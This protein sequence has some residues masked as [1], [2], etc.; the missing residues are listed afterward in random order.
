MVTRE[1]PVGGART[2]QTAQAPEHFNLI[3]LHWRGSG[4]VFFR[5]HGP[6]GWSPWHEAGAEAKDLPDRGSAEARRT[7]SW[8]IGNPFWT[9]TAD[10][11]QIRTRGRVERVR[12]HFVWSPEESELERRLQIAG[13]PPII[14]RQSWGADERIRRGSP[15][16][17]STL[18][19]TIV[20][21]TAGASP[22]SRAE[23]A[24]IV[25][26]IYTYHVRGNGWNDVGYNFLVDRFGQV[27]EGRYGGIERNV[28]GAHAVGFNTGS[29]GIA[30]L[31]SYG[32]AAPAPQAREAV[33]R[34][35]AWRLDVAHIDPVLRTPWVSSGR[36]V[37]LRAVSGHRDTGQTTCPGAAFYSQLGVVAQ[38]AQSI[39]LPKLYTPEVE[40]SFG[41][42]ISFSARLSSSLPW[43]VTVTDAAGA[44]VAMGGG[45]GRIVQWTW[46]SRFA[47]PGSYTYR[48]ASGT[49]RP[50]VGTLGGP[51]STLAITSLRANP[52]G[53]TPNADGVT[54]TTQVSYR[55]SAAA[56]VTVDLQSEAG[57]LIS[58]LF[59]GPQAAGPQVF[60]WDGGGYPDGRYRLVVTARGARGRQVTASA[61]IV[62]SRTLSGFAVTPT[63]LSPNGD[64]RSDTASI[65]FALAVPAFA[66]IQVLKGGKQIVRPLFSELQPGPQTLTWPGGVRDGDYSMAL[67]VTDTTGSV[68]Q[69][70]P[71]RIDRV[72]PRLR[73][74]SRRPV[75]L[76]LSEPARVTLIADGRTT[77]FRRPKAGVF[78][79]ALGR[80]FKRLVGFAED[81]A[82]NISPRVRFR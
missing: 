7:S 28:V 70:V 22:S 71:V 6:T 69:A 66:R 2:L 42:L 1:L 56:T 72:K 50:I 75:R 61:P 44:Q 67:A 3:G 65:S 40:G 38:R 31:G 80:P 53:F 10:R 45:T 79:V 5:A 51:A 48:I 27:F 54:D 8:R 25:R 47:A 16:Y 19:G 11:V 26:G 17:A 49:A 76:S 34:V 30:V 15:S 78:L 13:A 52:S 46:D 63:V 32:G 43:T 37:M 39:G 59:V 60:T 29:V 20:H 21:H 36:T 4:R 82:G 18:N 81:A 58:Q 23:S 35:I 62:L 74:A 9:G 14:T 68:T 12:G 24:A 55:L 57:V 73:L 64:G 77:S 41:G 33:A